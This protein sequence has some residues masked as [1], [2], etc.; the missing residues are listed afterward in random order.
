MPKGRTGEQQNYRTKRWA[1]LALLGTVFMLW[2]MSIAGADDKPFW[3]RSDLYNIEKLSI[4]ELRPLLP[5]PSNRVADDPRA[6]ALGKAL[7]FDARFSANG[8]VSCSSCHMPDR[9]FQ[10]DLRV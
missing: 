2:S 1:T 5:D 10:D 6:A 9:L 7:F 4:S 8:A 3:F